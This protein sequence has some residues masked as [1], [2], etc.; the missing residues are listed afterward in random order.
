MSNLR[1]TNNSFIYLVTLI[2]FYDYS[3]YIIILPEI[4]RNQT[5]GDNN[6]TVWFYSTLLFISSYIARPVGA[7][8]YG[9]LAN[10][11]G[12]K[13]STFVSI[14][15]MGCSTLAIG[16]TPQSSRYFLITIIILRIFQTTVMGSQHITN[17]IYLYNNE[18]LYS[19]KILT[20]SINLTFTILGWIAAYSLYKIIVI[21]DWSWKICFMI[22]GIASLLLLFFKN[23]F[24]EIK[25]D[26]G[27]SNKFIFYD[28]FVI[29]LT[30]MYISSSFYYQFVFK[31][32]FTLNNQI[33][34]IPRLLGLI[35]YMLTFL[36]LGKCYSAI[37][38]CKAIK[39]GLLLYLLYG[40]YYVFWGSDYYLIYLF[41]GII[42]A[43]VYLNAMY[44]IIKVFEGNIK[45]LLK[46]STIYNLTLCIANYI[47][48]QIIRI[49][50]SNND[51]NIK[52][53]IEVFFILCN[54]TITYLLLHSIKQ[55][56]K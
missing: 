40:C 41:N 2:E 37:E 15:V 27:N 31:F 35:V 11:Y 52:S 9:I 25:L 53:K 32:D 48:M 55:R 49:Y 50:G 51:L 14:V 17:L 13:V 7:F 20:I 47:I 5:S 33:L 23:S 43:F 29:I 54:F 8:L 1:L 39:Y 26:T 36:L 19:R 42:M 28:Y 16:L 34:E 22:S 38:T 4:I 21:L 45:Q 10:F 44:F 56:F 46:I 12:I 24:K 3:I 30:A 18:N 6:V